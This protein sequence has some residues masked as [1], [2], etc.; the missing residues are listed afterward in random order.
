ME[1][2]VYSD[3]ELDKTLSQIASFSLSMEGRRSINPSLITNDLSLIEERY[4]KTERIISLLEDEYNLD[5][6]PSISDIFPF[7]K[8]THMDLDG[9]KIYEVGVFLDSYD[10]MLIFL[11]SEE[12]TEPDIAKLKTE[13]LLS[14]SPEGN[15]LENHPRLKPLI[16]ERESAKTSRTRF[17][18]SFISDHRDIVQNDNA[19]FRNERVNIAISSKSGKKGFF[20][21]G[22][23]ASGATTFIEPFELVELNNRVIIAEERIRLE[24][25][26]IIHELSEKIRQIK[27]DLEVF[28]ENVV[29]FDFHYSFALWAKRC[30]A[31]HP[32]F[33]SA[34]NIIDARHPL[35]K[36]KAVP[37]SVKLDEKT[38]VLVL[39]GAN[40]GG[41]T[42]TMK[43]IALSA[44]LNQITGLALLSEHSTLPVFDAFFSDIGDGQS[45]EESVSTFSSHM[46][47]I[48]Y[49][50]RNSTPESL[51]LLDELGS[52]T[53]PD[54]AGSLSIAI[55]KYFCEHSRLTVATS[56]YNQVKTYAYTSENMTNAGMAF[57]EKSNRPVFKVIPDLPSDSHAI[58]A[59]K[60]ANLP[61]QIV[62]DAQSMLGDVEKSS[63]S[64]I[65]S[66]IRKSRTLDR[67][68]SALELAKREEIHKKE[69]LDTLLVEN[70]RRAFELKKDGLREFNDYLSESR[71]KLEN[72]VR[73]LREGT[74]TSEKT[75]A[76]KAFISELEEKEDEIRSSVKKD[77]SIFERK[78]IYSFGIGDM[79]ENEKTGAKGR[80][81]GKNGKGDVSV[82]FDNGLRMTVRESTLVPQTKT[83]NRPSFSHFKSSI[84]K[85]EYQ[86][87]VRGLRAHEVVEA[88]DNQM[89]AALLE[90]L[91]SFSIIH[92]YGNGVLQQTV[93]NYLKKRKEVES[94]NFALPEDGGMGKTYVR[95]LS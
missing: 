17:A 85:A 49:I 86:M 72:L 77:E 47:K 71:K 69:L 38:R 63:A 9:I 93:I 89:E 79:V 7:F 46:A 31:E 95:L 32:H 44:M 28:L 67:K 90:G 40:A 48:A 6:F 64:L 56:H 4:K 23:S 54:E 16:K 30:K 81:I 10:K 83:E 55:L 19:V 39:S 18:S 26:R 82:L 66:I 84:K 51:V 24:K 22:E 73:L 33:S 61:L 11:K 76:V 92:G 88:L 37:I 29:A 50:A 87:D 43:T 60:R 53:D 68:I 25:L 20:V 5:P 3:T 62:H 58:L 70:E 15:V 78:S 27:G 59:A 41:K 35:L 94:F 57:D 36:E 12:K 52:G 45:I 80:I 65:S 91:Q 1:N 74:L 13:I 8:K 14:I 42:V 75:K 34:V 21:S 2:S